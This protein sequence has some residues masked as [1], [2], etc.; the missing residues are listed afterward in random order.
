MIHGAVRWKIVS[1]RDLRGD[2][3]HELDRAG[4]GADDRDVAA[5]QVVVVPPAGRVEHRARERVQARQVRDPRLAQRPGRRDQDVGGQVARR[6]Y[7]SATLAS[8]SQRA[9]EQLDAE[10]QVAARG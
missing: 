8:S 3:R 6:S 5:G 1:R 7:G 10:P 4:A 9:C 2:L